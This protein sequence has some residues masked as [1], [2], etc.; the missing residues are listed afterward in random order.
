MVSSLRQIGFCAIAL[1]V[2]LR[3]TTAAEAQKTSPP[4]VENGSGA[5]DARVHHELEGFKGKVCLYAKNLDTG[6]TY[7]LNGEERVRTAST[8][9]AAIMVEAF[10]RVAEERSKWTDEIILTKEKKQPDGGVLQEFADN[11]RLTLRDAVNL[12]IVLSDNTAANLVIDTVTTDAVNARMD[13]LGLPKTRSLGKIGGGAYSKARLDPV[14]QGK[15]IGVTTPHEMVA[16]LEKLER[17]EVINPAASAEMIALLKRE[18]FHE[19]ITR[20][21]KNVEAATKC[22]SLDA[23]RADIGVIYSP[24]GRIAMAIYC[25]DMPEIDYTLD[26][27]ALLLM[28]RLSTILI[29]GLGR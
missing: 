7:S 27:P 20:G 13:S 2:T 10:A 25:D 23:L 11:T 14:N 16:L 19:G 15:G 3:P 26:N 28:S 5:L 21:L 29:E 17:G 9:K 4:L 1:A 12:M 22:G 18:Q 6:A 24:R 8:I